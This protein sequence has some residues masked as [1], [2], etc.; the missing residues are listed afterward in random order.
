MSYQ[1]L[2]FFH[3]LTGNYSN[4]DDQ[5]WN[6]IS[7]ELIKKEIISVN[8]KFIL[9]H[10]EHALI[11]KRGRLMFQFKENDNIEFDR[12]SKFISKAQL[13]GDY[14]KLFPPKSINS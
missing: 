14:L 11:S 2:K 10:K 1:D 8:N 5:H 12:I 7:Y 9:V 3:E 4:V 13:I 6:N